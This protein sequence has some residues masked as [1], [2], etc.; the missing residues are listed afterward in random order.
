MYEP[1]TQLNRA[2]P[3]GSQVAIWTIPPQIV[4]YPPPT[5]CSIPEGSGSDINPSLRMALYQITIVGHERPDHGL[6]E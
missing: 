5:Q 3:A 1:S 2:V 6:R 4:G